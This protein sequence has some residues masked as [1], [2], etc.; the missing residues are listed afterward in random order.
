MSLETLRKG[1]KDKSE[2][3]KLLIDK[4]SA[5]EA[6]AEDIAALEKSTSE[7]EAQQKSFDVVEKA[8]AA[9]AKAAQPAATPAATPKSEARVKHAVD[10]SGAFTLGVVMGGLAMVKSGNARNLREALDDTGF[11]AIGDRFE[12]LSGKQLSSITA[13]GN[14]LVPPA[15][16]S[17]IIE[18][19][20]PSTTFLQAGPRRVPLENGSYFQSGGSTGASAGYGRENSVPGYS[21][22]TFRDINLFAKELQGKTAIS[23]TLLKRGVSGIR[24]FV[25]DDLRAAMAETMD[26]NM[27]LGD[28]LQNRP[29]GIYN[30]PGTSSRVATNSASPTAAQIDADARWAINALINI[31]L[32]AGKWTMSQETAGYLEDVRDGNGNPMYPS[33]GAANPTFKKI[34]VLVTTNL[35]TNLGAG[36]NRSHISLIAYNHVLLGEEDGI[37]VRVSSE[38]AYTDAS[39]NLR[40]AAERD[41]TVMFAVARHDVGVRHTRAVALLT[42]VQWG[43]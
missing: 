28:G 34:P 23:N 2:A 40:S 16:A 10:D 32:A 29:L 4:A 6:T 25:D 43:R 26:L 21:E 17:E 37:T 35:P 14:L 38:A 8:E 9:A 36:S 18:F 41:E 31:N 24:A 42:D 19:L 27:F 15:M 3:H 33:M 7:L 12:N 20:R 13:T 1:L 30:I 5:P 39:G 22:A 11:T